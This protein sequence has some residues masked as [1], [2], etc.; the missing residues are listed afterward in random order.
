MTDD[1]LSYKCASFALLLNTV[2]LTFLTI[3]SVDADKL[4]RR[5]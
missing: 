2:A 3:S 4:A 5:V 1:V